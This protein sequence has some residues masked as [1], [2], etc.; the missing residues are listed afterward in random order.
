M[1]KATLDPALI[2]RIRDVCATAFPLELAVL[3]GS[4]ASGKSRI[5]SDVDVGIVPVQ[6]VLLADELALASSISAITHTEV[7]IVRLD[8][9]DPLLGRE[10]ARHGIAI[11]E[12]L[13]GAFSAY[14][15][16]AMSTWIEF[17]EIIAPHRRRFI[18]RLAT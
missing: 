1:T 16:R 11:Y 4:F 9:D 3:F 13:P 17:D 8:R 14:R 5:G 18:R 7:D 6:D 12:R 10:V 2:S 15:A